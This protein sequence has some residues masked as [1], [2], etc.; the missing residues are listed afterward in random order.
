VIID[1]NYDSSVS[2]APSAFKTAVTAAVQFLENIFINPITITISVGYGE[3]GG[4]PLSGGALGESETFFDSYS[5]TQVRNAL[6][7]NARSADQISAVNTL[8]ASDPTGGGNYWMSTAEA[9]ALGLIASNSAT[10]GYVG[11]SSSL[12]FDYDPSNGITA[13]TYDFNGTFLHEVTEVM[14]RDLFVG[15]DGIGS[16]AYTP[17]DLF[18]YSS[19]GVRTFSG[20]T[21]G[22]FS[23]DGGTT[24]LDYFNT[25]PSGDFGDWASS[26]GHDS[27]LA[28]SSSGVV[29]AVTAADLREMNVLGYNEK[30]SVAVRNDFNSDG[31]S[32]LI[33]QNS[34]TSGV[35]IDLLNGTSV[36]ASATI[37]SS[38]VV[39]AMGDFNHDGVSDVI[40]Q[41]SDGTPQIWFMNGTTV[42][43][44][45][46]L[47]N[48]TSAW[49]VIATD[50]FN[51]D[52][53]TDILWQNA[54]GTPAIWEMNG[55][56][57]IAGATFAN[58][59]PSWHE[60]G[61][62][63]FNGDGYA[64]I[65]W[66]N[67]DGTPAIWEMNGLTPI[68]GALLSNPGAS[69]HAVGTGDFNGDGRTDILWQNSDGTPSIW[70]M[71]G[72]TP[73]ATASL[74]NPGASWHV[75]G[76]SDFNGDGMAD[77]LWQ[78]S[79][80]TVATW[81]M[82]GFTPIA[83]IVLTNPGSTWQAKDDGPIVAEPA[84]SS[85]VPAVIATNTPSEP[86]SVA[87]GAPDVR[88]I[89]GNLLANSDTPLMPKTLA[90]V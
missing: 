55:T 53:N 17:L 61:A 59:G 9:K 75:I 19:P 15:S 70:E 25:N 85:A 28:F 69:W 31:L 76:T 35:M 78:N 23:L 62:G 83:G 84:T 58:P 29:N 74:P 18:H 51:G 3:V 63:D 40:L 87:L 72:T 11:F 8:P 41:A 12:P 2:S 16:N 10:D 50:D 27:F 66:Q 65:L 54:D 30:P 47:Y 81:E 20:T 82:N 14:G 32:D 45:A 21:T 37:P 44:T 43:S 13:G 71:N 86:A 33:L 34:V 89:D 36:T 26:A 90:Q 24:N 4:T 73:I 6:T 42:A 79:D 49:H 52:G 39:E 1:I 77:I 68:A 64:D 38:A 7:Q 60:I 67:T 80:G 46:T 56:T 5:Y 57:P 88:S 22:Y 48:P